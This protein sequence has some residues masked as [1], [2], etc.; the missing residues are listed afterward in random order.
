MI[1]PRILSDHPSFEVKLYDSGFTQ[2]FTMRA[3]HI[4]Q[5][6]DLVLHVLEIKFHTELTLRTPMASKRLLL[7]LRF[8]LR[9]LFMLR[10]VL[11]KR[12]SV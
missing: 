12:G 11:P 5:H 9:L 6:R 1:Y 4:I 3:V 2:S 10:I 8:T 7:T